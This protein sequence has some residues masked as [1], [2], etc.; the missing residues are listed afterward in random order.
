MGTLYIVASPIGNLGD[1]TFRAIEIL[2]K[3]NHVAAEDTRHTTILL[4]HYSIT[5]PILSLHEFNERKRIQSLLSFLKEEQDIALLSDAGTP[6]ISDPGFLLVKEAKEAGLPVVPIPGPCA[7]IAALSVSGLPADKFVFEGFLPSKAEA[8]TKRLNELISEKR[9]IIFY[10]SPHRIQE[11]LKIVQE[12]FGS[13]RK[14]CLARELTKIHETVLSQTIGELY[15]YF[16][17]NQAQCRGEMVLLMTGAAKD[18]A[19]PIVPTD[20]VLDLLLDVLP[21]KQAVSLASDMTGERKNKIYEQA[22][23]KKKAKP[24]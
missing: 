17:D 19:A 4:K 1:I 2:K 15:Q 21:L 3:V 9:T 5:K 22:L 20:K 24:F 10:E 6:L 23:R 18:L 12:I 13:E 16:N 14:A 11:T 8:K 7:A